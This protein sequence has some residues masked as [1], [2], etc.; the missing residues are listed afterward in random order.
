MRQAVGVGRR[1]IE[2]SG[3]VGWHAKPSRNN[4]FGVMIATNRDEPDA[5]VG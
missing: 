4:A 1:L 5:G 3:E 2:H